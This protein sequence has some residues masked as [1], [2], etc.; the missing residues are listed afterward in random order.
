MEDFGRGLSEVSWEC[1]EPEEV[2]KGEDKRRVTEPKASRRYPSLS[3]LMFLGMRRVSPHTKNQ[4]TISRK[5][6]GIY[7]FFE[8]RVPHSCCGLNLVRLGQVVLHDT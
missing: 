1:R 8:S 4:L 2:R 6:K 7:Y 5:L 3:R